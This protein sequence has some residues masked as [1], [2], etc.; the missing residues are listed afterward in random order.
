M[1]VLLNVH[2]FLAYGAAMAIFGFGV[3]CLMPA[4]NSLIS[5]AVPE[6]KRGLAFGLFGTSLGLLGLPMPWLGAQMWERIAPQAPFWVTVAA[7]AISVPIAWYKFVLPK[8]DKPLESDVPV[9]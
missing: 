2:G 1:A 3:G 8:L 6:D 7:C 9:A 4:Y 5:K